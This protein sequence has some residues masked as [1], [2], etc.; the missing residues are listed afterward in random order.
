MVDVLANDAKLHL[1]CG[2]WPAGPCPSQRGHLRLPGRR[3]SRRE[4][5]KVRGGRPVRPRNMATFPPIPSPVVPAQPFVA[6]AT[7]DAERGREALVRAVREGILR[8]ADIDV[9]AIAEPVLLY[10]PFWRVAVSVDGFHVGLR[11]VTSGGGGQSFP[12]PSGG[13]RHKDGVVMLAARAAFPYEAKLPPS[14]QIAGTA[15]VALGTNE[16]VAREGAEGVLAA[17]EVVDA[18]LDEARARAIAGAMFVRAVSPSNALY[19]KYEPIVH[20]CIFCWY[21]VYY[22]RYRYEGEARRHEGEEFFVSVSGRTGAVI[23]A[24][25]PSAARAVTSKLRRFLSFDWR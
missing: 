25:H 3:C 17:G 12:I 2:N 11:T 15:P 14:V 19:S 5:R 4:R 24:K 22:A 8:P 13:F 23:A 21:P 1:K 7:L 20:S 9:A 18:D 16:L 6:P 10:V